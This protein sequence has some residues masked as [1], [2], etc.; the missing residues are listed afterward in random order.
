LIKECVSKLKLGSGKNE[1]EHIEI[2]ISS[3][4]QGSASTTASDIHTLNKARED[5]RILTKFFSQKKKAQ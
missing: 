1:T 3:S 5:A 2:G 4:M